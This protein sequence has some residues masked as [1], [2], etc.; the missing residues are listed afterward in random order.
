[1]KKRYWIVALAAMI[2]VSALPGVGAEEAAA[3][4]K[5]EGHSF[6]HKLAMYVPNRI[7]DLFDIV[8]LRVRAGPLVAVDAR[9]TKV[10]SV[11]AGAYTTVYVGLPGPRNRPCVKL[12][13][14][15]ESKNGVEVSVID[16]TASGG[17]DPD[18]GP[19]E[20]GLGTQILLVGFDAG[21][22]PFEY[23]ANSRMPASR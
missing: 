9:V 22:E 18:Y 12:P 21:I 16:A 8:R 23:R 5:P 19:T 11:F 15:L 13:V 17:V 14:G 1:M 4:Q 3:E 2:A 10:A 7:L 6:L 20:I